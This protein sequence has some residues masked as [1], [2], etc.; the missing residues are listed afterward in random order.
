MTNDSGTTISRPAPAATPAPATDGATPRTAAS[1]VTTTLPG[2][3]LLAV[4]ALTWLAAM[5][6]SAHAAIRSASTAAVATTAAAYAM[7]GVITASLLGGVTAGLVAVGLTARRT[8]DADRTALR[9][10]VAAGAGLIVG[11]LAGAVAMLTYG[12]GSAPLVLAGVIAGAATLGGA[13][14]GVRAT[15][16]LAA[17]VAGSIAV[18]AAGLL[19]NLLR[20]PLLAAY[21]WSDRESHQLSALGWY[22]LTVSLTSGL[23]AGLVAFAYL[24]RAARRADAAPR[25][26]AY[27]AAGAGPGLAMLLAELITKT[28]GARVLA[29]AGSLSP[30]D[31]AV[32]GILSGS[33]VNHALVV[34]FVGAITAIIAFGRTLRPAAD[35][36]PGEPADPPEAS[37]IPSETAKNA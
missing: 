17:A 24:R 2:A 29:Q 16:V 20:N 11:L 25:W 33:R 32:Q 14:A 3:G 18:S 5:L 37:P 26:P 1:D 21:G 15:A 28:G 34:L 9:F 30:A 36:A 8:G 27:L 22:A 19:L 35:E 6:W 7:P 23:A 10:G 31:Q 4:L 12:G 13:L